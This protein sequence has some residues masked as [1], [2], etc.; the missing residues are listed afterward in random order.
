MTNEARRERE[1]R[2]R[3]A[4]R[5]VAWRLRFAGYRI[6]AQRERTPYGEIDLIAARGGIAAMVEVKARPDVRTGV[7]SVS[8]KQRRRIETAA[9]WL[10]G[11]RK[12]LKEK[13]I[14]FDIAVV[15]GRWRAHHISDAWRPER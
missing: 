1:S 8:F 5:L 3:R 15:T 6:L 4:E 10:Q 14:R 12:D 13:R 11:R 2:G 7:E 9:A